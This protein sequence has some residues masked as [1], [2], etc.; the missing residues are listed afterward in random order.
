MLRFAFTCAVLSNAFAFEVPGALAFPWNIDMYRGA[1]IQPL[2]VA[3]RVM[4]TDTLPTNG[5]EPPMTRDYMMG[6]ERNPLN[7]TP[8]NLVAGKTL[9]GTVCAPCHGDKGDGHGPVA[10]L[11]KT[12]PPDLAVGTSKYLPDGYLFGTIRNGTGA[13]PSYND[14]MSAHE[15]WQLVLFVRSLQQA[16]KPLAGK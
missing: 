11:L 2:E 4:P 14:A 9:F 7:A 6:H 16:Q 3:P 12:K 15:R 13:M 10:H 8:E 5:A 1:P